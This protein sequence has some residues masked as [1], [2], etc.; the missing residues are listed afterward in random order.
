MLR[1]FKIA[2]RDAVRLFKK[3]YPLIS[4]EE[5]QAFIKEVADY[6][7]KQEADDICKKLGFKS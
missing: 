7:M 2:I 3:K 1:N 5:I 4:N 6:S